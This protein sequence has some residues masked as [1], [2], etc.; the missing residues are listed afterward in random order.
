ML[1]RLFLCNNSPHQVLLDPESHSQAWTYAYPVSFFQEKG[2]LLVRDVFAAI[3][4]SQDDIT[5][6][7]Q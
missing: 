4:E 6:S 3:D 7:R 2:H 1:S 5:Q